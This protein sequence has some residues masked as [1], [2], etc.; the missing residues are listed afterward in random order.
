M[1]RTFSSISSISTATNQI[2]IKTCPHHPSHMSHLLVSSSHYCH[3]KERGRRKKP[4]VVE[5]KEEG[6]DVV[7]GK[8]EGEDVVEGKTGVIEGKV[9]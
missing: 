1:E 8:E 2:S 6:E 4:N 3:D 9:R 7:E 5:G